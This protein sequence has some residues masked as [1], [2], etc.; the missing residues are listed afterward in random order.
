MTRWFRI[1]S[2]RFRGRHGRPPDDGWGYG[3]AGIVT[4]YSGGCGVRY[5]MVPLEDYQ[6]MQEVQETINE[7][8]D[9]SP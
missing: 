5:E 6:G 3:M 4:L 9:G 8:F 1:Q 7:V 2:C